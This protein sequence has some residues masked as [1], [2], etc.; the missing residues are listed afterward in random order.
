MVEGVVRGWGG[1]WSVRNGPSPHPLQRP[2][3][4]IDRVSGL[5]QK[6]MFIS[7]KRHL[8][9]WDHVHQKERNQLVC[10][11]VRSSSSVG[12]QFA[13]ALTLNPRKI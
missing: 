3:P 4:P 5:L 2:L 13:A 8:C 7:F 6:Q 9:S 11:S 1:R 12:S 10:D